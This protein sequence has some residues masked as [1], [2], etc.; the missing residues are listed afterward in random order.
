MADFSH[1]LALQPTPVG[2]V[3]SAYAGYVTGPAWLTYIGS[4]GDE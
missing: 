3:S 4:F 1:N 2:V